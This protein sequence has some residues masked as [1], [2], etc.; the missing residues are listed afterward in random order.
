MISDKSNL[1]VSIGICWKVRENQF[2]DFMWCRLL[3]ERKKIKFITILNN[4]PLIE[5]WSC[6]MNRDHWNPQKGSQLLRLRLNHYFKLARLWKSLLTIDHCSTRN[7]M[8]YFSVKKKNISIKTNASSM[9]RGSQ[10]SRIN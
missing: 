4:R 3:I 6:Q 7:V 10:L 8:K 1:K 9:S 5:N 2:D